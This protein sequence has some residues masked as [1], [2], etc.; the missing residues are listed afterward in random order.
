M[1]IKKHFASFSEAIREGAKLRP[2]AFDVLFGNQ[3]TCAVGAGLEAMGCEMKEGYGMLNSDVALDTFKYLKAAQVECPVANNI[4]G[5]H[6]RQQR[7]LIDVIFDL[8]DVHR[9]TR[10]MIADWVETEEEKLGFVT[11]VESHNE[12]SLETQ[13][14]ESRESFAALT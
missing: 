13:N 9:W 12:M 5:D 1:E 3:A 14:V 7:A 10:E 8:N 4:C 11:L 6:V 2:Q